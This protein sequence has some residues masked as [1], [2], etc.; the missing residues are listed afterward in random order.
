MQQGCE[1]ISYGAVGGRGNE[2]IFLI[3]NQTFALICFASFLHDTEV[4]NTTNELAIR[5][6]SY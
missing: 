4:T 5:T 2:A 6:L 1:G 3:T